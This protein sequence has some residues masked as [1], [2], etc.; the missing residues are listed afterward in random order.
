[1]LDWSRVENLVFDLDNTLYDAS[2][3]LFRKVEVRMN[4][5]IQKAL[6]IDEVQAHKVQKDY[7]RD[8]GTTLKG[9]VK[10]DGINPDDFFRVCS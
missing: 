5:F 8:Y 9:L 6:D 10:C 7:Y 3:L 2:T 4:Q 1:M